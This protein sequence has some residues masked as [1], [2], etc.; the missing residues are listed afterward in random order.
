MTCTAFH[1]LAA[2]GAAVLTGC[3]NAP[4]TPPDNTPAELRSARF[5]LLGEVHDNPHHHAM[6]ALWLRA[7][8]ADGRPTRV[9]FEQLDR[10]LD[11]ELRHAQVANPDD[12]SAVVA[13]GGLDMQGWRWPMHQPIIAAALAGGAELAGGNLAHDAV[14][15]V[16]R[17]GRAAVPADLRALL[18]DAAWTGP[19]ERALKLEIDLS[20]CGALPPAQWAPMALAQRTRDAAMARAMLDAPTSARVVLIAG[21]GH[22]RRDR[23]V[24]A[25][26]RATGVPATEIVAVGLLEDGPEEGDAYDL[27]RRT[28]GQPRQDPCVAF[29]PQRRR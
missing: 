19:M 16:V 9:V 21:N 8:L 14:R 17:Q 24:P 1:L 12:S 25:Y 22:V 15:A 2:L 29:T 23:G 18:D 4:A 27:V 28:A 26:L 11:A 7:L 10:A 5:V 3:A 13:A 20:H 6:R